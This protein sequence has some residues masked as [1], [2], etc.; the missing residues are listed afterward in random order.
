MGQGV[1]WSQLQALVPDLVHG[2]GG[3][4][5]IFGVTKIWGRKVAAEPPPVGDEE[6]FE[7]ELCHYITRHGWRLN[8]IMIYETLFRHSSCLKSIS[9][10][11]GDS[12]LGRRQ[13]L[14]YLDRDWRSEG[15]TSYPDY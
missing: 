13:L 3:E 5:V 10:F 15:L 9:K 11:R 1:L 4:S 8:V 12:A 2:K 14:G 7:F 6:S